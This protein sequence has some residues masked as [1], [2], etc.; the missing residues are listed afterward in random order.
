[1]HQ[2]FGK[3]T[4]TGTKPLEYSDVSDAKVY[5][6]KDHPQS[7]AA[8]ATQKEIDDILDKISRGGYQSLTDE[9]KKTLFEASKKLN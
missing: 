5:D 7:K 9:E 3:W 4:S 8:T 6:I 1:L 2:T